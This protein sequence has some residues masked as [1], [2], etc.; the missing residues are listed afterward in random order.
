MKSRILKISLSMCTALFSGAMLALAFPDYNVGW[1]AW[2]ALSPLLI[3]TVGRAPR[4]GFLLWL[5]CGMVFFLV[6]GN[7][8]FQVPRYTLLHHV[9]ID[10][11][12]ASYFALFGLTVCLIAKDWGKG[13]G[14]FAAPFVWVCFEYARAN[15]FF[16]AFP[17][18]LLAHSQYQNLEIMQI[19]SITGTYGVSLLIAAVNSAVAACGLWI[20]SSLKGEVAIS[21]ESSRSRWVLPTCAG[22]VILTAIASL[23]YGQRI[24]SQ[25][26]RGQKIKVSV[27]QGNIDQARKWDPRQAKS[28]MQAYL[29]LTLEASK[30]GPELII[31]PEAA[32]PKPIDLD[33]H[34]Y[35]QAHE[36]AGDAGAHLLIGSSYQE[37]FKT[38]QGR[39]LKPRNSA[40]LI[41]PDKEN[42]DTQRYDKIHLVPF[43]E[44]I[45]LKGVIPWSYIKVPESGKCVPGKNFVLFEGT[46]YRFG[47]T[48]CWESI[49]PDLVR[50]FVGKGAQF[51]VNIT[52][53]AWFGRTAAPYQALAANVFRSVENR[54]FLV[55]CT[56]TGVSCFIDP[57]GRIIGRVKDSTGK[58]IFVR[59]VLTETIVATESN[60]IY[61]RYGDWLAWLCVIFTTGFLITAILRPM[62]TR[63]PRCGATYKY[64]RFYK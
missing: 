1:L 44:Y 53:E 19:A 20:L 13:L 52:N 64:L 48:I 60:G 59:G 39:I 49:F 11:Y 25:P 46:G 28:I 57:N 58:D 38:G 54:V 6:V 42:A 10:L 21:F 37:K 3:A 7:W 56:N 40:Y 31:W 33:R 22:V 63:S 32:T 34:L 35:A 26:V 17:W 18:C 51:V 12:L 5:V 41:S 4:Y 8:L 43:G 9:F 15:F 14:F 61:T 16:L 29:D 47:V 55:R 36:I 24:I 62:I 30:A 27:V 45:P 23:V 50:Q 2:L